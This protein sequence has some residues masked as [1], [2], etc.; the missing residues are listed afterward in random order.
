MLIIRD[1][2]EGDKTKITNIYG[3]NGEKIEKCERLTL[4]NIGE[5]EDFLIETLTCIAMTQAFVIS[6]LFIPVHNSKSFSSQLISNQQSCL[7]F[8]TPP[9]N[10]SVREQIFFNRLM[11]FFSSH[12]SSS[13]FI[14]LLFLDFFLFHH[15]LHLSPLKVT[16]KIHIL[17]SGAEIDNTPRYNK[18]NSG[19]YRGKPVEI[20]SAADETL[21]LQIRRNRIKKRGR[22][23]GNRDGETNR[24]VSRF[25]NVTV[26]CLYRLPYERLFR[27]IFGPH[28][29]TAAFV[30][31]WNWTRRR[32]SGGCE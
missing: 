20:R 3:K 10:L 11:F 8:S 31:V 13:V 7:I 14:S 16:L 9:Y 26:N 27:R 5:D 1:L 32:A 30:E 25:L 17:N 29:K 15:L 2:R 6:F 4:R 24:K 21:A 19:K 12:F 23:G 18:I 28:S 22:Y